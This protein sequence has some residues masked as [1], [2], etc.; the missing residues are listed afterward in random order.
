MTASTDAAEAVAAAMAAVA[1]LATMQTG[2]TAG[3]LAD[4]AQ[5]A[6][7]KAT[8]AYMHAKAAS[9][10]AAAAEDVVAAV[11]ARLMAETS[12]ASA[13]M[14]GMTA[15]EKAGE[16]ETAAMAELMIDGTMKS[17]G[18][19]SIDA[20]A[21]A[22]SVTTGS[23]KNAQTV[24][25]GLIKDMNPMATGDPITGAVFV[26]AMAANLTDTDETDQA[27]KAVPYK[28]PRRRARSLSARPLTRRTTWPA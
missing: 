15:T 17:V 22:S 4:E 27:V 24:N 26:P 21:G 10:A 7:D 14:Y 19:T 3:G 8:M 28:Q 1:N 20:M 11:E 2:A 12:M 16:A 23:G 6:A 25:T 18:E 9:E 13:V 5:T